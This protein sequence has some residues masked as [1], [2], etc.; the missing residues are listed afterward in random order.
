MVTKHGFGALQCILRSMNL[1][2]GS[3]RILLAED[4]ST[5][6]DVIARSLREAGHHVTVAGDGWSA[7]REVQNQQFDLIITDQVMPYMNGAELISRVR[8]VRPHLPI[9]VITGFFADPD[10]PSGIPLDIPMFY[11]PFTGDAILA[12]VERVLTMVNPGINC[13]SI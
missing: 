8:E 5:V 11:K 6:R 7:W 1:P 4:E 10:T 3:R 12:E 2:L 13:S 9:I